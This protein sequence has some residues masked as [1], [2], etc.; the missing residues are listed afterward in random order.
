[1][2]H[3]KSPRQISRRELLLDLVAGLSILSTIAALDALKIYFESK[4]QKIRIELFKSAEPQE[5]TIKELILNPDIYKDRL[6][7]VRGIA[8]SS[9]TI[10]GITDSGK[11]KIK[12]Y[13]LFPLGSQQDQEAGN[14]LRTSSV[15][16]LKE[17][18]PGY[19]FSRGFG[20]RIFNLDNTYVL[21]IG[22]MVV[23]DVN[24]TDQNP[25]LYINPSVK[26][27]HMLIPAQMP[28]IA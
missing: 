8:K 27:Q 15:Y 2:T 7:S 6:V 23:P 10:T 16:K 12:N 20:E 11:Y 14:Y 18:S 5:E 19:D 28:K 26:P 13:N 1:M 17:N 22:T 24:Q 21:G 4:M 25:V 3:E 9:G